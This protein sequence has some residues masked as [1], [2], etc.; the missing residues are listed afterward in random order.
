MITTPGSYKERMSSDY[1]LARN[2]INEAGR[3]VSARSNDRSRCNKAR[4]MYFG[5]NSGQWDAEDLKVLFEQGRP[6]TQ[7]NVIGPKIDALVGSLVSD[8]PD[9]SW[10]PVQGEG[11]HVTEAIAE[12]YY[13][14]KE[15]FDYDSTIND[16]FLDAI[17]HS[18][19][20]YLHVNNWYGSK[21]IR[22]SREEPGRV[23]FD[24]RWTTNNDRDCELLYRF[25][26]LTPE[27][28]KDEYSFKSD[29]IERRIREMKAN[30]LEFPSG[31]R[32]SKQH[33]DNIVGDEYKIV[34]KH[35]LKR[36]KGNRLIGRRRDAQ[37]WVVFPIN[38]DEAYCSYFAELNNIDPF[39]IEESPY[40]DRMHYVTTV[41]ESLQMSLVEH[42]KSDVQVNGLPFYHLTA[43][44]QGG[45]DM[46]IVEDL[47]DLQQTINKRESLI[48][49]MIASAGGGATFYDDELFLK[50]GSK[51]EFAK[52]KNRPGHPFFV[53]LSH[54]QRPYMH[55][56]NNQY[57]DAAFN[58]SARMLK[59]FL[60]LLSRA[61]DALSSITESGDSGILFERKFQLNLITNTGFNRRM[62]QFINNI[63]EGFFYQWQINNS[64]APHTVELKG[65]RRLT[66]N[67]PGEGG[68]VHNSVEDLPR[69]RVVVTENAKS[70]TFTARQQGFAGEMLRN[71]DPSVSPE[72]HAIMQTTLMNTLPIQADQQD[73]IKS[74]CERAIITGRMMQMKNISAL[75]VALQSDTL[76]GQQIQMSLDQMW[77]QQ[78]MAQ[79]QPMIGGA[80][81]V[82]Q[83]AYPVQFPPPEEEQYAG[84]PR[85]NHV[86]TPEAAQISD[87][88]QSPGGGGGMMHTQPGMA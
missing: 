17:I 18:G 12:A 80:Q 25:R 73:N 43:K 46:G 11:S 84:D 54:S 27:Q 87:L 20:A 78:A 48:T 23:V 60:P 57:P 14:D 42:G 1:E 41:C 77:Q 26:Y 47:I 53:P 35:Y 67:Q 38:R 88:I 64:G 49:E 82:D 44:R 55:L 59:D 37:Q 39:S 85:V 13:S 29:E 56:A 45:Q 75:Q 7:F 62:R 8:I 3:A 2:V 15:L 61:S 30:P 6:A 21:R 32:Q 9:L 19:C 68:V 65:G 86:N 16:V 4:S 81:G 76:Q 83:G 51:E 36:I 63:G 34:E 72:L 52:N 31:G 33:L 71:L 66:L 22:L 58:Q 24:P 10:A 69:C 79:Q 50:A 70:P 74:A 5:A 28:L 40:E